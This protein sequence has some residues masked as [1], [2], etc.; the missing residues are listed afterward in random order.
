MKSHDENKDNDK[1]LVEIRRH[2]WK[3]CLYIFEFRKILISDLFYEFF[4]SY[5]K[6]HF[7]ENV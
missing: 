1:S 2:C 3:Y 6:S 4:T 7:F 5:S